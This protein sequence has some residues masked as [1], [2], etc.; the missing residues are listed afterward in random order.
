MSRETMTDLNQNTLIGYTDKRGTAWH[1]R[2]D[3]QGDEPNH[4]AGAIPVEDVR[5]RLFHW[6]P[7][8]ADITAT[9]VTENGVV[10]SPDPTRKAIL[11][12]DTG[13]VLGVFSS[14]YQVHEY[15]EWLI[16][17]VEN[18]LDAD[19]HIGSAGLL[20]GGAVAWVQVEMEDTIDTPS[21]VQF[22]PFLTAAT[23]L[24][25]SLASTYQIGAQVVVCDNTLSVAL[26]E[27]GAERVRV[28]HTARSHLRIHDVRSA[29]NIV[30]QTADA[31]NEQVR[32]LTETELSRDQ[33]TKFLEVHFAPS[34]DSTRAL[35]MAQRRRDELDHWYREH[36]WVAP[37]NGTAWGAL[38]AINTWAHHGQP[39]RGSRVERNMERA[40]TGQIK[41]ID[42]GALASLQKVLATA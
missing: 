32:T 14:S 2:A 15:N 9:A 13:A 27:S 38:S 17:N 35:N 24:D 23:S 21:G 36:E 40:V 42:Q 41:T 12:S 6:S 7:L 1:Y 18:L 25:G 26:G 4:Y 33:W 22:R 30:H 20:K 16:K 34:T 5:R 31:F 37:W 28:K 39:V 11:R 10:T 29:L 19:L 8:E 3:E